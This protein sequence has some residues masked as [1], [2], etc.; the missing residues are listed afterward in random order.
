MLLSHFGRFGGRGLLLCSP[1]CLAGTYSAKLHAARTHTRI[2]SVLRTLCE[3]VD[4]I[5]SLI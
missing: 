5:R 4:R 1:S 3:K 2:S